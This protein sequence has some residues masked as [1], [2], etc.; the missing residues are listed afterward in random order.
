MLLA[1]AAAALPLLAGCGGGGGGGETT[2]Q[3][4]FRPAAT[5]RVVGGTTRTAK[6]EWVLLVK[7]RPGDANILSAQILLP[8]VALVDALAVRG[9]CA[10]SELKSDRC[11]GKQR[12][13]SSRVVTPASDRPLSGPVYVVSGPGRQLHLAYVLGGPTS[14]LLEGLVENQPNRIGASVEEV[15]DTAM[16]SF[17]LRIAGGSSGYLVLSRDICHGK[18]M[19]DAMF[20]G[21]EGQTYREE[22]PL[23]A[24]CGGR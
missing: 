24:E 20:T 12:L 5:L 10:R 23:Q 15:P 4:P 17:E 11:A 7:T 13:G 9:L 2:P 16:T 21:Q 18:P 8:P 6:P 19:A 14:L 3:K 1:L 22:V